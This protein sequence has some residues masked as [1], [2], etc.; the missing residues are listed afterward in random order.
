MKIYG[1]QGR[2]IS[3]IIWHNF[4]LVLIYALATQPILLTIPNS[5]FAPAFSPFLALSFIAMFRW[6]FYLWPGVLIGSC[7]FQLWKGH[8]DPGFEIHITSLQMTSLALLHLLHAMLACF[9][10]KRFV[11]AELSL[12]KLRI[13]LRFILIGGV[14]PSLFNSLSGVMVTN[15]TLTINYL[16]L[17]EWVVWFLGNLF[18]I[19]ILAPMFFYFFSEYR[20]A[21]G[22]KRTQV[23]IPTA[24]ALIMTGTIFLITTLWETEK[25]QLQFKNHTQ[26]LVTTI[27]TNLA[28]H[29]QILTDIKRFYASSENVNRNE[30]STYV[31]KIFDRHP[32]IK[33]LKWVPLVQEN[34][35]IEFEKAIMEQGLPAFKINE[36]TESGRL[37]PVTGRHFYFPVV[38]DEPGKGSTLPYG[39]DLGSNMNFATAIVKARDTGKITTTTSSYENR[40]NSDAEHEFILF[41]P[42]YDNSF[43]PNTMA[44]R[45]KYINGFIL[46]VFNFDTLINSMLD[47]NSA[48]GIVFQYV[49]PASVYEK[50]EQGRVLNSAQIVTQGDDTLLSWQATFNL[51]DFRVRLQFKPTPKYLAAHNS[52]LA[53]GTLTG[54]LLFTSILANLSL[55][56]MGWIIRDSDEISSQKSEIEAVHAINKKNTNMLNS[57]RKVQSDFIATN[58]DISKLFEELLEN[59]LS[60]TDSEYGFIGEVLYKENNDPYLK[61]HAITN[62][63]WDRETRAFYAENAPDGL[64][65]VNLKTLFG[66]VML[67][68][69]PVITNTP[70]TDPRSG[71]IPEGHP[72][73]DAFLGSPLFESNKMIGMVG[74]ANSTD[75]Y[76]DSTIEYLEPFFAACSSLIHARRLQTERRRSERILA[77]NEAFLQSILDNAVDGIITINDQ[78]AI[79]SANDAAEKI[80]GY[81]I[82]EIAGKNITLFMKSP[83][84]DNHDSHISTYLK[85]GVKNII[86]NGREVKGVR[87]SGDVFPIEL[88]VSQFE[89]DGDLVFIGIVRDISE[90]KRTTKRLNTTIAEMEKRT[91][92]I[93]LLSELSDM[94]Q[95]CLTTAEAYGI[96]TELAPVLFPVGS[97]ALNILGNSKNMLESVGTWGPEPPEKTIFTPDDCLALRRGRVHFSG[98]GKSYFN[99][100]HLSTS[101]DN[102]P[103]S[104]C[105]P[106]IGQGESIGVLELKSRD[107]QQE[108]EK[109]KNFFTIDRQ[110]LAMTAAKQIALALANLRLRETLRN[111][112]ISDPLTGL[113]NRRYMEETLDREV[114]RANR[115]NTPLSVLI[116]DIDHFKRFNDTFGHDAG[117]AVLK[118]F[119]KILLKMSR[120]ED[121][122]C[123]FGGEEFVLVLPGAS[124]DIA[125]DRAE[126]IRSSVEKLK[127]THNTLSLGKLSVSIGVST[128][129]DHAVHADEIVKKADQALYISKN[130]GRN[131]V[132]IAGQSVEARPIELDMTN[133]AE[134]KT[135]KTKHS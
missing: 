80:F 115:N 44:E 3:E 94:L 131:R 73:L 61:T 54:C 28:A 117:D 25:K 30:F 46:A 34:R 121:I 53:W 63:A 66:Q 88:G 87:K 126:A 96:I 114:H 33:S 13:N 123:R 122:A 52:W 127:L 8:I 71:G 89:K 77:T 24:L 84:K 93:T 95:T 76:S 64:E 98:K 103:L 22:K 130:G 70:G 20:E 6:G 125:H 62:I 83:E 91:Q 56:L 27:R 21:W 112:S 11:D 43:L 79:L 41:C 99:C 45:R 108:R 14:I 69:K 129:P 18:G 49:G 26:D 72:P 57:I 15:K 92:D 101:P 133:P 132:T 19:I 106:L 74:I 135:G 134:A 38:Y 50:M 9:L 29:L 32:S 40:Q 65:F 105:V 7:L 104:F 107:S 128:F 42:F 35:R 82:S 10:V 85:T 59:L 5:G 47:K 119:G 2:P 60:I 58:A 67:T 37:I 17:Q 39:Y 109:F 100:Q 102:Q 113:F 78:G 118:K 75:G 81:S 48:A 4:L 116:L 23:V 110:D 86:G 111:Q 120:K 36:A 31:H 51:G 1:T 90:R 68:Q 97:G 16:M 55:L 12:H 124:S